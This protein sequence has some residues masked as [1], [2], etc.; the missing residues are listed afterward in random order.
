MVNVVNIIMPSCAR[1]PYTPQVIRYMVDMPIGGSINA[2]LSRAFC[3]RS[4]RDHI[5]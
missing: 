3:S 4:V 1:R 5:R 2:R